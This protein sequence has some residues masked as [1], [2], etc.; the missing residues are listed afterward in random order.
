MTGLADSNPCYQSEAEVDF[1]GE[2]KLSV[3]E[4][5]ATVANDEWYAFGGKKYTWVYRLHIRVPLASLR[6]PWW[7]PD[8]YDTTESYNRLGPDDPWRWPVRRQFFNSDAAYRRAHL[9][10]RWGAKVRVEARRVEWTAG[11]EC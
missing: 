2:P 10:G 6:D 8:D 7:R 4:Y 1:N 9:L 5:A 3:E 11:S